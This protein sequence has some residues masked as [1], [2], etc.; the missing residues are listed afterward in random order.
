[1]RADFNSKDTQNA[2]T[3]QYLSAEDMDHVL[4]L[5]REVRELTQSQRIYSIANDLLQRLTEGEFAPN[6][7]HDEPV[8]H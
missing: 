1:M 4:A 8:A 5:L 2:G 3:G 7:V 6:L